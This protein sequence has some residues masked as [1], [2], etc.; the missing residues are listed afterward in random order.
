MGPARKG[1]RKRRSG[2]LSIEDRK[3]RR[4]EEMLRLAQIRVRRTTTTM[5]YWQAKVQ[6]LRAQ[7]SERIQPSLF[8]ST[9]PEF[10]DPLLT[11]PQ[12]HETK[13]QLENSSSGTDLFPGETLPPR[14][15]DDL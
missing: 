5:A 1:K 15:G 10:L 14:E 6:G 4:A 13:P 9:A 11:E 8:E 2:K 12:E 3:L 7:K